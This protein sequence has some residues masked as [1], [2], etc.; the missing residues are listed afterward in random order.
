MNKKILVFGGGG[1]MGH[2]IQDI[3]KQNNIKNWDI[4]FITRI[5]CDIIDAAALRSVIQSYQ[6]DLIVNSAALTNVDDCEK[7]EALAHKVNFHAVAQMAAHCSVMDIPMIHL[8][9]D[10]VFDG[11]NKTPY[12]EDDQMNPINYYGASK[13]MGEEALR[14]ELPW[15]VIL[16]VS[17]IFSAYQNN[18]MKK[19]IE[20]INKY[21][22]LRFVTDIKSAPTPATSIANAI[23]EIA[24][25]LFNGKVDGYGT[26]H[27]CGKP[28]ASRY[29]FTKAVM[30]EYSPY[31]DRRPT[32]EPALRADFNTL[33]KRP[34]YSILDCS[35]IKNTYNIEQPEWKDELKIAMK[36]LFDKKKEN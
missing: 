18:I 4:H 32:I 30:E 6:P 27:F 11:K 31:T 28:D 12:K 17:S 22:E 35:K 14:H 9:T 7:D 16:R 3:K 29:D 20:F 24:T 33:A 13:M 25:Q 21:D 34:E 23:I 1:Q 36:M 10:Y 15:H 26:F 2:A 8:S 19:S 5:E